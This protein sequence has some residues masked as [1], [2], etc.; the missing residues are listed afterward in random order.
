MAV[1][2]FMFS[3]LLNF[4]PLLSIFFVSLFVSL[5]VTLVNKFLTNQKLMKEI[6]IEQQKLQK[7]LRTEK[8]P[9]K[10]SKI[11][12][13]FMELNFK[14]MNESMK[15]TFFTIIPFWLIF[16]WLNTH[17]GYY[18]ILPNSNFSII[19]EFDDKAIGFAKI[20]SSKNIIILDDTLEKEVKKTITWQL[21]A[22]ELGLS[23]IN[24]EHNNKIYE[25]EV[26]ISD[27][28]EY[29]SVEKDFRKCFLFSC[30]SDGLNKIII[31]HE[32]IY[33]FKDIPIFNIIPWIKDFGW[34]GTYILFSL[35]FSIILRKVFDVY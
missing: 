29:L 10:L 35:F 21:K 19:V 30:K 3:W 25:K 2:D 8:N 32:K 20:N 31:T 5:I 16:A 34:L 6:R 24:I 23:K 7:E 13:R 17:M 26:L 22:K 1:L 4:H 33:P 15:A 28:R 14:Y 12:A 27:K 18:P 11:N 9:K